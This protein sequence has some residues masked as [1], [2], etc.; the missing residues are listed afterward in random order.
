GWQMFLSRPGVAWPSALPPAHRARGPDRTVRF[1]DAAVDGLW[2]GLPSYHRRL[3]VPWARRLELQDAR[4][5]RS[6]QACGLVTGPPTGDRAL[7]TRRRE[8]QD[9]RRRLSRRIAAWPSVPPA[10]P[11]APCARRR[12]LQ[13]SAT[14]RAPP[15]ADRVAITAP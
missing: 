6:R 1:P 7:C 4:R 12:E 5:R 13:D 3:G 2:V 8:L 15:P 11:R 14:N 9:S 10:A